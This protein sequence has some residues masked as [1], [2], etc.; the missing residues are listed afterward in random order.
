VGWGGGITY[1]AA[2]SSST[3]RNKLSI[4]SSIFLSREKLRDAMIGFQVWRMRSYLA[5]GLG[6]QMLG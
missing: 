6:S 5:R 3:L 1:L 4:A 2:N